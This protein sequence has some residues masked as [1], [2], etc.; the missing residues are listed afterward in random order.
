MDYEQTGVTHRP[1]A[2][3][4]TAAA[5]GQELHELTPNPRTAQAHTA[6]QPGA[7]AV[8]QATATATAQPLIARPDVV[9]LQEPLVLF[10]ITIRYSEDGCRYLLQHWQAVM[11]ITDDK[12]TD[13]A[14]IRMLLENW[15]QYLELYERSRQ[16]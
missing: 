9:Y 2:A 6:L 13:K 10:G 7:Q 12:R 1:Q 4:A 5:H 3:I 11:Q 15:K 16:A 14:H 8:Q